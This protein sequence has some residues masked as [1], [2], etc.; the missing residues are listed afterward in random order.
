MSFAGLVCVIGQRALTVG[1]A[2]VRTYTRS[3]VD[4]SVCPRD[5]EALEFE[6][7][8]PQ[9]QTDSATVDASGAGRMGRGPDGNR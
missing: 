5:Y 4:A 2:Y 3:R 8:R 9:P 6:S 7:T 1:S